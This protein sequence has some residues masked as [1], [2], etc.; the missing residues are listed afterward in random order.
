MA[1]GWADDDDESTPS[2]SGFPTGAG[3][4]GGGFGGGGGGG[5]AGPSYSTRITAPTRTT[6]WYGRGTTQNTS[7]SN[8]KMT[9][10]ELHGWSKQVNKM[11]NW[12]NLPFLG[13]QQ[14]FWGRTLWEWIRRPKYHFCDIVDRVNCSFTPAILL[15]FVAL[16]S[17]NLFQ[18]GEPMRCLK[19]P[20]LT[21]EEFDY[22]VDICNTKNVYYVPP[23]EGIPWPTHERR[24]RELGYYHWVPITLLIQAILFY[25]P[26]WIWTHMNR[27][28]GVD[29]A[30]LIQEAGDINRNCKPD[31]FEGRMTSLA[32]MLYETVIDRTPRRMHGCRFGRTLGAYV[33]ILYIFIKCMYLMNVAGQFF[34]LNAFVG[35]SYGLW[36]YQ[37]L[38]ALVNGEN[39][40]DSPV[41]PRLTLCDV[42]IRR[43]GDVPRYTLQCHLRINTYNE[44][45]Y[46]FIWWGFLVLSAI[47]AVNLLYY[48][49]IFLLF[50]WTRERSVRYLLKQQDQFIA[51]TN[52]RDKKRMRLIRQFSNDHLRYDGVLL[53]WFIEGH[54]GP[55]I[56]RSLC[57]NLFSRYLNEKEAEDN[58]LNSV[59]TDQQ[60][61][62][63]GDKNSPSKKKKKPSFSSQS[64]GSMEHM[65]GE[66]QG[67]DDMFDEQ[68]P[69]QRLIMDNSGKSV[70]RGNGPLDI[71]WTIPGQPPPSFR[72]VDAVDEFDNSATP[73]RHMRTTPANKRYMKN[74]RKN[75]PPIAR[76][77][78]RVL[79]G[80]D[81]DDEPL[82][83]P[84]KHV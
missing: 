68:T 48:L 3:G 16:I 28:G 79:N 42:P 70:L 75:T 61:S 52:S 44:K 34:L 54:A 67:G 9:T 46:L 30:A 36:G 64:T 26:N 60:S 37:V 6:P 25:L 41:F 10:G 80:G 72:S 2:L 45:I 4:F 78:R 24:R 56:A 73:R 63:K 19:S 39:W 40:Q 47:T 58:S 1:N 32:N 74:R 13:T 21:A 76:F 7:N 29:F 49:F 33:S 55:L 50:P 84:I 82:A 15:F 66:H 12:Q 35:R 62:R 57:G 20:E 38:R 31:E 8:K 59:S 18:H 17:A 83:P 71:G 51:F 43:L 81:D 27:Q 5:G 11:F 65:V 14:S 53:F 22:A 69:K 23:D 77:F